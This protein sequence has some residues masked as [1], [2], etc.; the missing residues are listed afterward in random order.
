MQ[1]YFVKNIGLAVMQ[2]LLKARLYPIIYKLLE[3]SF[4]Y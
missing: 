1:L 2:T 4:I 3:Y